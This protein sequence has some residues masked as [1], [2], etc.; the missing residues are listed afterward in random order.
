MKTSMSGSMT[1]GYLPVNARPGVPI[2]EPKTGRARAY[3]EGSLKQAETHRGSEQGSRPLSALPVAAK[4]KSIRQGED[5]D[6]A[7]GRPS[8]LATARR[9]RHVLLA[10]DHVDARSR[11]ATEGELRFP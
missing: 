7:T 2:P 10:V 9:Y 1:G 4:A 11:V 6:V 3:A 5:D 8:G